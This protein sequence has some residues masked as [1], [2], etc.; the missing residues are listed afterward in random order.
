M[1]FAHSDEQL[2]LRD[3]ARDWLGDHYPPEKLAALAD[4]LEGPGA[5]P[6][7]WQRLEQLGW[8]DAAGDGA[9]TTGVL[10]EET[11]WALLPAPFFSTV[12]LAGP[13][14]ADTS[15][16]TTLAW[17]EP[18]A[19]RLGD[20]I[21]TTVDADGRVTG[22]KVLVPDLATATHAVVTTTGGNRLV[23]L[24]DAQVVHRSTI[25]RTRRLGDLVLNGTPSQALPDVAVDSARPTMLALAAAEAV[26]V[27]RKV[28]ELSAAHVSTREQFGRV[29]GTYQGV[30]H[31]VAD[32]FVQLELAR[33]LAVWACWAIDAG[34]P[35]AAVAAASA[36]SVAGP[37]AV[38]ATEHAIQVHGGLGFTWDSVLHRYYKRAQW[39][40]AFEGGRGVQ[41]AAIA[42]QILGNT[43]RSAA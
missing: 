12:A 8:V 5:E 3:A 42:D 24:A 10:L 30:S 32:M 14:G 28:L 41:C 21:T 16:P 4:D 36:K 11:G 33:S 6:D 15:V 31:K 20:A 9:V 35:S 29:I 34:D 23:A 17:A 19:P 7:V 18:G 39:L 38:L 13:L 43:D 40:D 2:A 26:G 25:D 1:D 22:T 27:T 37:A